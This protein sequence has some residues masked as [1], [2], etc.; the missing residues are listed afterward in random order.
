ML[1]L[2]ILIIHFLLFKSELLLKI[3]INLKSELLNIP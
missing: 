1:T 2:F 3:Y